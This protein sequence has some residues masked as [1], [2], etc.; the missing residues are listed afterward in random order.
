[1]PRQFITSILLLATLIASGQTDTLSIKESAS[2][3]IIEQVL[4][5]PQEKLY[6]HID[7][8]VYLA[9]ERVWFRA[10]PV[11]AVLHTPVTGQYVH[12][13]LVNPIDSVVN[14]IMVRQTAGA[15]SGYIPLK[16]DLPEGEYT[17]CAFTENM[18]NTGED[19]FFK[20]NILV[21]DPLSATIKTSVRFSF[22]NDDRLTAELSFTDIR[23]G[24]KTIPEGLKIRV[25]SRPAEE[26]KIV[27]DTVAY[28]SFR[29]PAESDIRVLYVETRRSKRYIY[30]PYPETDFD[31]SFYPEGGYL[32]EGV[33][34]VVAFKALDSDG[35]PA[36]VNGDVVDAS[37]NVCAVLETR[38]DGMGSFTMIA[39]DSMQY[40]AECK[41]EY[42][43]IKRFKLPDIHKE[44]YV[45]K[46]EKTEKDLY[47]SVIEPP[48]EKEHKILYLMLHTR[49]MLHYLA[50]WDHNFDWVSFETDKFPSGVTQIVLLDA[51]M[52]PLS[53]RL[54]F[55]NNNDQSEV[56]L[57][58]DK[59][60]YES[61]QHVTA[62][63]TV[64]DA[65]GEPANGSFSVSVT[66]DND[67]K[68]DSTTNILTTLLLTSELK[69]H[70]ND[71]A[72]YFQKDN[73]D[74]VRDLDLLMLTNGWRR[75]N[76]PDAI[77]GRYSYPAFPAKNGMEITGKVKTLALGKPVANGM[78][79]AFSWKAGFYDETM[80]DSVGRFAFKGIE[81]PDSTVFVIQALD[82]KGRPGVELFIDNDFSPGISALPPEISSVAEKTISE[83]ENLSNYITKADTKYTMENGMRTIYI[84]GVII[85]GK[86]PEKKNYGF[87][88][89][90]PKVS[91]SSINMIDY[92][93]IEEMHPMSVS[94]II[95]HIPFTQVVDGKVIIQRMSYSLNGTLPAVLVLDDMI[96][97]DYDIDMID[98]YSIERVAVLKGSQATILGGDGAGGAIVITTK[99][100]YIPNQTPVYNIKSVTPP[101]YQKPAEFYSPRYETEEQRESG[102]RDLRTT[103]YWNP[104][105]IITPEGEAQI[106]FYSADIPATYTL[107]IQGVTSDGAVI[108][109][110]NTISRK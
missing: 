91:Q 11:D 46:T 59:K 79:A 58:T 28:Y 45:L 37:G 18:L 25:N 10:W 66:D 82:K 97:H 83:Q 50:P 72:W 86:A 5:L 8:P 15:F 104:N 39:K 40:Y 56:N 96:I 7:K 41:N 24:R 12:V 51:N 81:F 43:K 77:A 100:G 2:D 101:G 80:T 52:N 23:S 105:V 74:A 34:C 44:A 107:L 6:L 48:E 108:Q 73:P 76:I 13:E 27:S 53:E 49:G 98:P 14:R 19:Y 57:T 90:M 103:I 16:E 31:V 22:E 33:S 54:V 95:Y 29:L 1:M 63:V 78:V 99:K 71:P 30:I 65:K 84:E 92:E 70:I 88:Y 93:Q 85:K 94:E 36:T 38:H 42:G 55:F 4:L 102:P 35:S 64:K 32:P 20:K 109:E 62:R 61:R 110:R 75:Y 17:I 26:V 9:G 68:P 47:V 3:K 21:N 89:Y 60:N 69:G 67:I 106:D 87:S